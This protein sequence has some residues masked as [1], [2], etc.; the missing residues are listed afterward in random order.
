M[1]KKLLLIYCLLPIFII[2]SG[3]QESN[4]ED[5]IDINYQ[6]F[7]SNNVRF[8]DALAENLTQ[9]GINDIV[10]FGKG[11]SFQLEYPS[12]WKAEY[13][14][15]GFVFF[16]IIFYPENAED[17]YLKS[18]IF[19]LMYVQPGTT[20]EKVKSDFHI[21]YTDFTEKEFYLTEDIYVWKITGK[22]EDTNQNYSNFNQGTAVIMYDNSEVYK[23]ET[24]FNDSSSINM[25]IFDYMINSF[26][27]FIET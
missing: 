6:T 22:R 2:L 15:R 13:N 24:F 21:T 25:K 11:L 9:E 14:M 3:C 19:D 27:K 5:N 1:E 26:E 17:I 20:E 10:Q 8:P 23:M 4:Q 16:S 12:N 18:I 7:Y